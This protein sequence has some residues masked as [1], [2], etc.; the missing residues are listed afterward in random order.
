MKVRSELLFTVAALLAAAGVGHAAPERVVCVSK[1][2]NEFLYAIGAQDVLVGRDL[3]SVY[4]PEIKTVTS[5]GYH[6]ALSAEGIISLRP[7]LLLT[8]GNVGPDP[9]LE[10]VKS[11]GIPVVVMA[12]GSTVESA[13]DLLRQLGQR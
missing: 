6:R 2:I 1:Q 13:Q 3:T 4:P 5:V 7:T 11:V 12:P 9:V 8:D 10:Q